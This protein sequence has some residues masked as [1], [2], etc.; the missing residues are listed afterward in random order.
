MLSCGLKWHFNHPLSHWCDG[1][2]ESMAR[3]VKRCFK[4][5]QLGP[6]IVFEELETVLLEI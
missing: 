4:K 5:I 3:L 2:F 1:I 6:R